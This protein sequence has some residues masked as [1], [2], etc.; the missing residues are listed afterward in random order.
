[1]IWDRLTRLGVTSESLFP[2]WDAQQR[3][4]APQPDSPVVM[5][6]CERKAQ[7]ADKSPLVIIDSVV[8]F[9]SPEE[10][11]NASTKMRALYNRCRSVNR[12]G[13]TVLLLHHPNH[14]GTPR[15]S[16][17]FRPAADQ[18]FLVS[19]HN[20]DGSRL[21]SRLRLKVDKSRYGLID[22]ITYE[23]AG[24]QML[25]CESAHAPK[26]DAINHTEAALA[27]L[28]AKNPGIGTTAFIE[29]GKKTGIPEHRTRG[30]LEDGVRSG[31]I[32]REGSRGKGYHHYL[33]EERQNLCG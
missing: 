1:V 33:K 9:L 5:E 11:E 24:G 29:T 7:E 20:P 13:G 2:V 30:F 8:S 3:E 10:D 21:L 26:P 31:R 15:G 12:A 16:S 25:R 27:E 19:N 4:E 17:D 23:Y 18:G 32:R 6:W 22:E 28:L 14:N